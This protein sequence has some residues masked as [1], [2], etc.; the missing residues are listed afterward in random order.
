MPEATKGHSI[1]RVL[2]DEKTLWCIAEGM[3]HSLMVNLC[4]FFFYFF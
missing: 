3:E 1:Q 2:D 4:F